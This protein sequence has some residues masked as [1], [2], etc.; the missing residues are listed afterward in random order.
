MAEA[1][2]GVATESPLQNV[3]AFCAVEEGAP[4]LKFANAIG[5]FLG[6][7]L[8][9]TPIVKKL[10]TA[11]GV[12]EMRFPI[13]GGVHVGHGG[14]DAT[15]CHDG[16]GFSEQRFADHADRSALRER[17]KGRAQSRAA[18]A[19]DENVVLAAFIAG[20]HKSLRSWKVPQA[21]MRT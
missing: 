4:L 7:Q 19:N 5:G 6:M 1:L 13:V 10:S 3:A 20:G 12:A 11:H 18:G 21:T 14:S 15:F 8:S 16:V 17:L 2:K 9:H